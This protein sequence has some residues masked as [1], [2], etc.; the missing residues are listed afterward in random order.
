M[1]LKN[2]ICGSRLSWAAFFSDHRRD[3]QNNVERLA[4][5]EKLNQSPIQLLK[6]GY[7]ID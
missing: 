5:L 3:V 2:R 7:P 6:L 1:I 4:T